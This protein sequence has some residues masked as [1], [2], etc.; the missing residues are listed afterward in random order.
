MVVKT[1]PPGKATREA[2][3]DGRNE[4]P[5]NRSTPKR[6]D[7]TQHINKNLRPRQAHSYRACK[8]R[9]LPYHDVS[10]QYTSSNSRRN[11]AQESTPY[12]HYCL[13]GYDSLSHVSVPNRGSRQDRGSYLRSHLNAQRPDLRHLLNRNKNCT[14]PLGNPQLN[15]QLDWMQKMLDDLWIQ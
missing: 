12:S 15:E 14:T 1:K 8:N 10:N 5:R 2:T 6:N 3:D 11:G 4:S 13:S 7:Q 9:I